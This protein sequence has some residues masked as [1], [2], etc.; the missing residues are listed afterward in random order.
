MPK[1]L[2]AASHTNPVQDLLPLI[3]HENFLIRNV[4]NIAVL[5]VQ[6]T[7][8]L[9]IRSLDHESVGAFDFQ[10]GWLA[11]NH[12]LWKTIRRPFRQRYGD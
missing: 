5:K 8:T 7:P 10:V 11:S 1:T 3:V 9:I 4:F 12:W 6:S 2:I